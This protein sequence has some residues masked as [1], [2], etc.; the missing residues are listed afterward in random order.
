MIGW[1]T[2]RTIILYLTA[3][4]LP[5]SFLF[6]RSV[7]D[8]LIS[9]IAIVFLIHTLWTK[10]FKL[11]RHPL[12]IPC[13]LFWLYF[14]G[15]SFTAIEPWISFKK[16]LPWLR[17]PFFALAL[18]PLLRYKKNQYLFKWAVIILFFVLLFFLLYEFLLGSSLV[19]SIS[20]YHYTGRIYGPYSNPHSGII[21]EA[22]TFPAIIY[23]MLRL[24]R[25]IIHP[26]PTTIFW[27]ITYLAA[28]LITGNR[29]PFFI[30]IIQV[31]LFLILGD[32]PKKRSLVWCWLSILSTAFILC[33]L[34]LLMG[35][36]IFPS[37]SA[38]LQRV[39]S[40]TSLLFSSSFSSSYFFSYLTAF[41]QG[42]SLL[43]LSPIFGVGI[44]QLPYYSLLGLR[45][46]YKSYVF[47]HPHN[48]YIEILGAGGFIGLALFIVLLWRIL[49]PGL[50]HF[51]IIRKE[52]VPLAVFITVLLYFF[53]LFATPS[54]FTSWASGPLW[55]MIGWLFYYYHQMN[56]CPLIL[57]HPEHA[58]PKT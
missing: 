52:P 36:N 7:P 22:L 56:L 30:S 3:F 42:L 51:S 2:F 40:H 57:S 44:G 4:L 32:Y 27:L 37:S 49:A 21:I 8:A 9:A 19:N 47:L 25:F 15:V 18:T 14:I 12:L 6:G 43:F 28:I 26:I 50:K 54:F 13:Y 23:L 20:Q 38:T 46:G 1:T 39:I 17:Y 24:P 41:S 33:L 48:F 5:L 10:N 55:L 35:W 31:S 58:S 53:P 11:F 34:Q 45:G 29:M 16:I